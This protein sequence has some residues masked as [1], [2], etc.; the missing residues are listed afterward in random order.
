MTTRPN[1]N[2][3]LNFII[4][5]ALLGT[6]VITAC[7]LSNMDFAGIDTLSPNGRWA[8]IIDGESNLL[9]MELQSPQNEPTLISDDYFSFFPTSF[10]PDSKHLLFNINEGWQLFHIS[11]GDSQM[12]ASGEDWVQFLPGGE[13]L[14]IS[15]VGVLGQF[16][17]IRDL[18]NIQAT[19]ILLDNVQQRFSNRFLL[20]DVP[21]PGFFSLQGC[22]T[23][24]IAS[25]AVWVLV[26]INNDVY[27][28]IGEPDKPAALNLLSAESA[29]RLMEFLV[30]IEFWRVSVDSDGVLMVSRTLGGTRLP[31]E[32]NLA[33]RLK[34]LVGLPENGPYEA[35]FNINADDEVTIIVDTAEGPSPR[36]VSPTVTDQ[37]LEW[38]EQQAWIEENF[39][40]QIGS[41][42][43]DFVSGIFQQFGL[44]SPDGS[45]LLFIHLVENQPG[46]FLD[47]LDLS[48][49]ASEPIPL[50]EGS[51]WIPSFNFSPDSRQIVF[52]SNLQLLDSPETGSA[53][54]NG[55]YLY[56]AVSD[57]TNV[58]RLANA[59]EIV[60]SCWH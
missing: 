49:T 33:S 54:E 19:E 45:K 59:Q 41:E 30:N 12:V 51:E 14:V 44:P 21:G 29:S 47:L 35:M 34:V 3:N 23:N 46:Y 57:G 25:P 7:G 50:V 52:E 20:A 9:L 16:S 18:E 15:S 1:P 10:S 13:L 43:F 38:I 11:T 24:S 55:R 58:S 22:P 2:I 5:L 60:R 4:A 48:A 42:E 53:L 32:P 6:L 26:D 40:S 31:L 27:T 37:L 28:L 39:I 8:T 56:Q 17:I 36:G